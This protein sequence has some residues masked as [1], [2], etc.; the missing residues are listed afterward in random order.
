MFAIREEQTSQ[1]DQFLAIE[2]ESLNSSPAGRSQTNN[3]ERVITTAEVF[4]PLLPARV[5]KRNKPI[6]LWIN[7]MRAIALATIAPARKR[8]IINSGLAAFAHWNNVINIE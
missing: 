4:P 8:Q 3:V 1:I 5:K 2:T 7:G 6:G